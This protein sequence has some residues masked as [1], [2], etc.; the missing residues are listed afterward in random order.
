MDRL[1]LGD[2]NDQYNQFKIDASRQHHKLETTKVT[3]M[4]R[5]LQEIR[6]YKSIAKTQHKEKARGTKIAIFNN[7]SI[8]SS[9]AKP[10]VTAAFLFLILLPIDSQLRPS[11]PPIFAYHL[12]IRP[13][14]QTIFMGKW[15]GFLSIFSSVTNSLSSAPSSSEQSNN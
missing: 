15:R 3:T 10:N 7:K 11:L 12:L 14:L 9:A 1:L 2:L 8:S 4:L 5:I 13:R 6:N